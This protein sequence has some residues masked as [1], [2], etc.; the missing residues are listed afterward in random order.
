[1]AN[2][3]NITNWQDTKYTKV[4]MLDKKKNDYVSYKRRLGCGTVQQSWLIIVQH[5]RSSLEIRHLH[6]SLWHCTDSVGWYVAMDDGNVD[7][8]LSLIWFISPDGWLGWWQ[9]QTATYQHIQYNTAIFFSL[10]K[11]KSTTPKAFDLRSTVSVCFDSLDI[12]KHLHFT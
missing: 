7:Y 9:K 12:K 2:I 10:N 11:A 6:W 4:P 8:F 5:H 3:R 1:M